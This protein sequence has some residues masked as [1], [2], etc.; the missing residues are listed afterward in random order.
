MPLV[1]TN[2]WEESRARRIDGAC[3]RFERAWR[4]G[5][6]IPRLE[7]FLLAD[8]FEPDA[9]P[10]LFAE[11][12]CVEVEC[13]NRL[14]YPVDGA[15]YGRRFARFRDVLDE[16]LYP[17]RSEPAA[18]AEEPPDT[19]SLSESPSTCHPPAR[20]EGAGP[21]P[22]GPARLGAYRILR[23]LGRGGMGV[24]YLAE[25]PQLEREVALKVMLP[26]VA[27]NASARERF[28]REARAVAAIQDDHIIPVYQVG[29][30]GGSPFFA[31]PYLKGESLESYLRKSAGGEGKPLPVAEVLRLGR[32][33]A[34]GLAAAHARGLVH[35]DIK[36]AN[37]WL[38]GERRRVKILDFGLVRPAN[39]NAHLTE[40]GAVV[41]TPAYMAP[42]QATGEAVDA[43]ADLF[44]LGCVLY[45]M[46]TGKSAFSGKDLM[47]ILF[48]VCQH[49]PPPPR[50][51][52]PE[53]PLELSDL[54][55][56]LLAKDA[57]RRPDSAGEVAAALE[58]VRTKPARSVETP[59]SAGRMVPRR[60]FPRSWA[61][62][63]LL[64]LFGVAGCV[65]GAVVLH[66][67]SGKGTMKITVDDD[68]IEVTVRG[69]TAIIKDAA[70]GREYSLT[71][72][73]GK[74]EK[75]P[76]EIE[77][78]ENPPG[79]KVVTSKFSDKNF[80]AEAVPPSVDRPVVVNPDKPPKKLAY[81]PSVAPSLD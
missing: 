20:D 33:I 21:P 51:L 29:E 64:G 43:R 68:N 31:M 81:T 52:V 55:L 28:L 48:A 63:A 11:L 7:E 59:A 6:S 53:T 38:E 44:S 35:R 5:G 32:E 17:V 18:P 1:R 47:S 40:T 10:D 23:E 42:E 67:E 66:V 26:E 19:R 15:D 65:L 4:T 50:T 73:S 60:S 76:F 71:L 77:V 80:V 45:R 74:Q 12:L 56:R 3:D 16:V 22:A 27:L 69:K 58:A 25:D 62:A 75:G 61:L 78:T 24:V 39:P 8:G 46:A 49:A 72:V 70:R 13:R 14:G 41:G 34:L 79:I 37:V 54:I 36:P 9:A 2:L 57:G 30:E